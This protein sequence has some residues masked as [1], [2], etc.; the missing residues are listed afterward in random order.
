MAINPGTVSPFDPSRLDVGTKGGGGG[1]ASSID[2]ITQAYD[3]LMASLDPAIAASQ[4]FAEGQK[5]I[6]DALA[7]GNIEL[8]EWRQAMDLLAASTDKSGSLLKDIAGTI[9]SAMG[10]LFDA[11]VEGGGAAG[12]ALE[13]LAKQLASMALQASVFGLLA[14]AAPGVFGAGG[15][16]DLTA[17][18]K[19]NVFEGGNVVPFARGGVVNGPTIFPM[20]NGAGLMGEAGP[21]AV[22]PLKRGAGGRLGV[23]ASGGG[24]VTVQ[25]FNSTGQPTREERS[26]GPDGREMLKVFIGEEIGRGTFAPQ[27]AARHGVGTQK[28]RR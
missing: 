3:S 18:A 14:K 16:M 7:A 12:K 1:A 22:M 25:V 27:L 28:V 11:I 6:N 19:G 10:G 20:A 24:G 13:N 17:S 5:T 21:E 2:Q 26:Q 23:E 8:P 15:F 9:K 4:K